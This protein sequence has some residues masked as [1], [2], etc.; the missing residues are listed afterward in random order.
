M[1]SK[2]ILVTGASSGF[3]RLASN[4]LSHSGHTVYAAIR[5][6]AGRN[7]KH[8]VDIETYAHDYGVD[9]RVLEFD[10]GSQTSVDAGIGRIVET[11]GRVDVVVHNAGHMAF[12]PA[13]AFTAEQFA[14][15]Y[16]VN[17]LGTQRV[18]RSVLPH[19]RGR[20]EGL[21]VWVSSSAVA[22]GSLPYLAPYFAAKAALDA[23]AVQYARELSRWGI[24]T[25][26]V[27]PGA[28]IRGPD[29]FRHAG[30]PIDARRTADYESGPY[31]GFAAEVQ[32]A[33][34]AIVPE[35][36]DAGVVAGA[37]VQIVDTPFGERPFRVHV[38]PGGDGAAVAFAVIDRV[39]EEM[40][41]RAGL[42]DLLRPRRPATRAGQKRTV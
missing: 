36:A 27:V 13:E 42:A 2:V 8:L 11:H 4:A 22:G 6:T 9:I 28:F 30:R 34:A 15:I 26:I 31:A 38:D 24:E 32:A 18:N 7:A 29:P 17:V 1:C 39:R 25:S 35:D 37:I 20:G 21:L 40:L 16:D 3:G 12:G 19:M 23:V 5:D 10:I 14:E 41:R 33:C